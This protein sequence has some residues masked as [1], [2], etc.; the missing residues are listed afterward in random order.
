MV[1]GIENTIKSNIWK[2]VFPE[3]TIDIFQGRKQENI[4]DMTKPGA[5]NYTTFKVTDSWKQKLL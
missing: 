3:K 2:T 1:L 5:R 4:V